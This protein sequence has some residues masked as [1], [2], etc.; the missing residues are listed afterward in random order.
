MWQ[1]PFY[2]LTRADITQIDGTLTAYGGNGSDGYSGNGTILG[3]GEGGGGG[4]ASG[5]DG[6]NGGVTG[7]P[8]KPGDLDIL[9]KP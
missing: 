7:N 3:G 9:Y 5:G 6:G 1:V 4:G 8:S 2:I